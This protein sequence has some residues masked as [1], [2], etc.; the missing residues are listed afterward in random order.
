MFYIMSNPLTINKTHMKYLPYVSSFLLLLT[1][2]GCVKIINDDLEKKETKLVI[3]AAINPDSVFYVN[4][5][6]TFNIFDDESAK[7]LPF[8]DGADVKLYKNGDFLTTLEGTGDGYYYYPGFNPAIGDEYSIEASFGSYK[9]V[10]SNTIIPPVVKIVDFD[11][12]TINI[13][14]EYNGKEVRYVGIIKYNDPEG[15]ANQYQ[16][17]CK[18]LALDSQGNYYWSPVAIWSM[19]GD[20]R[21][22]DGAVGGNLIWSD[23]YTDGNEVTVRFRY[24][25]GYEYIEGKAR[26]TERIHFLF[27]LQS[28]NKDY[29]TYLKSVDVYWETGGGENPFAEPVVIHSNVENGYGIFGGYSQD[30]VSTDIYYNTYR[31]KEAVK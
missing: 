9:P 11:T 28:I 2:S 17:S 13:E 18:F 16:L 29:Y 14:N 10:K 26:D 27:S 5:S 15:V 20:E 7:N 22:F 8:I 24:Y 25:T 4:L 30:T 19:E 3:N 21:F 6:R 31:G 12:A 23:K 1:I